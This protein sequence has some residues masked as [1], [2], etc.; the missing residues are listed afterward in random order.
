MRP[1]PTLAGALHERND[2]PQSVGKAVAAGVEVRARR[3]GRA[4]RVRAAV[5]CRGVQAAARQPRGTVE[6]ELL[7]RAE[8]HGFR[9]VP[10]DVQQE[11]PYLR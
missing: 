7:R 10:E 8:Q 11:V 4:L 2:D 6:L 1:S 9:P 3:V 5:E